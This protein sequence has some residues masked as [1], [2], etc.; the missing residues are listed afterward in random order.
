MNDMVKDVEDIKMY[1]C[2]VHGYE[3]Q[4]MQVQVVPLPA[5]EQIRMSYMLTQS[6]D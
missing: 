5:S 1:H 4:L 3:T 2:K 6:L